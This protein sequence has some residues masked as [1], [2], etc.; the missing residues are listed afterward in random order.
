MADRVV[1]VKLS[2][3]VA[4]YV[5]GME[6]AAR[7]TR[8][9]GTE[10]ERLAQQRQAFQAIGTAATGM[11]LAISAGVGMAVAKYAEFDQQ[12]SYVQAATHETAD[13]MDLLRDAA[14]DAGSRTVFSATEAAAAIEELSKAGLSTADILGGA[15]DGALDAAAAGGMDVAQ[16]AELMAS[17]L[18]QFNLKGA[19]ASHV[20]DLLAAGAGKAQ[21]DMSDLGQ[22]LNQAGLV[23]NQFGLSVE[24]TVGTLAAFANAGMLGSDAGTSL[25]TMLLRLANPTGE[26]KDLME[27][28]GIAAYDSQGEFVGLDNLAGQLQESLG[29]MTQ[30]QRD[31]TLAMIFGQDAIRGANILLNEGTEGI[32]EWTAAVDDQGYAA[33][34][35]ALRLDN[36]AGD[37]EAFTGAFETLMISMGEG[38]DGPLRALVQGLTGLVEAFNGLPDWVKQS[39]LVVSG[40]TG[41]LLV[42]GGAVTVF[43]LKLLEL[44]TQMQSLG[45]TA[46]SVRDKIGSVASFLGGPF[47]I[48]LTS[49][50][51]LTGAWAAEQAKAEARIESYTDAVANGADALNEV[52]AATLQLGDADG[53]DFFKYGFF[54]KSALDAA[55]AM[56]ISLRDVTEAA[57]GNE[58]AFKRIQERLR[59]L[60]LEDPWSTGLVG[61]DEMTTNAAILTDAIAQTNREVDEA[62]RL[63][64][65]K[66]EAEGESADAS[67]D[68]AA[69]TDTVTEATI[70]YEAALSAAE[71][72][73]DDLK[74]AIEE[75]ATQAYGVQ[76]AHD[77]LNRSINDSVDALNE[78]IGAGGNAEE[79]MYGT[80]NAG[81]GLRDVMAEIDQNA[82]DSAVAIL[83]NGGTV[84]DAMTAYIRGRDRIVAMLEQM[85]V[86]PAEARAWAD[87]MYGPTSQVEGQLRKV[88]QAAN[89]IPGEKDVKVRA[90]TV[91]AQKDVDDFVWR[92]HG[93]TIDVKVRGNYRGD[94]ANG[95]IVEHTPY[96]PVEAFA[97][98][99]VRPGI[100]PGGANIIKFA[101]PETRWEAY[102]SGKPSERERNVGVW[103]SA[104][105]RLGVLGQGVAQAAP[106]M[107]DTLV[108]V[109]ADG[110]LIGRMR[111]EAGQ[112]IARYDATQARQARAGR[113]VR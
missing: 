111:V 51:A 60:G 112:Q 67:D 109:D 77:N 1:S 47:G 9:T 42:A 89:D 61:M 3:Q 12:M 98:G 30:A 63:A 33:E 87:K 45:V 66:A 94:K 59:E 78:F 54:D 23:A 90:E 5:R 38:A 20:A 86:A 49:V 15:L 71:S 35:A 27:Q 105:E 72:A 102:I 75:Y 107:P 17:T 22:A 58:K 4:E 99:G 50:I 68:A 52:V 106:A 108:V 36:L 21:G 88:Q 24:D 103:V 76:E 95:G 104:G 7:K 93:R 100:Y 74:R 56:G 43:G 16:T 44:R 84:D 73:L 25:R 6:E 62:S 64:K 8:E 92:N 82:R 97:N 113:Q 53:W 101:E 14:L 85:G 96:G 31:Q 91:T 26:V 65:Q 70:D 46:G 19:D 80:S 41:V 13:N 29:G 81:I 28:L 39:I 37:W 32:R 69:A 40:L 10:A 34:T 57:S 79:A 18:S 2:A 110:Q 48:A 55:E 83:E 11:G